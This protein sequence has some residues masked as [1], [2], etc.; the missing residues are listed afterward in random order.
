VGVARP[1]TRSILCTHHNEMPVSWQQVMRMPWQGLN[2]ADN[3]FERNSTTLCSVLCFQNMM[4]P[5]ASNNEQR[6][7]KISVH[8]MHDKARYYANKHGAIKLNN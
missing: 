2:K 1:S 4:I 5:T 3:R 8:Q 6:V 7:A